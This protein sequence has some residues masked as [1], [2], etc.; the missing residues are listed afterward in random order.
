MTVCSLSLTGAPAALIIGFVVG[1][2]KL[3]SVRSGP[4]LLVHARGSGPLALVEKVRHQCE[5]ARITVNTV[6]I[7]ECVPERALLYTCLIVVLPAML[8]KRWP[9]L[10]LRL[11]NLLCRYR[12]FRPQGLK[13]LLDGQVEWHLAGVVQVIGPRAIVEHPMLADSQRRICVPH[14][15]SADPVN[16]LRP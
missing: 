6:P 10:A 12:N 13:A 1:Q 14:H 9:Q 7:D 15:L 4:W 8:D 3:D 11:D 16:V 2:P 5:E